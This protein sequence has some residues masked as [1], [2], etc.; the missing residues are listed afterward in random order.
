LKSLITFNTEFC[1]THFSQ[2]VV[3]VFRWLFVVVGVQR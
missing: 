2:F 3:L 1:H